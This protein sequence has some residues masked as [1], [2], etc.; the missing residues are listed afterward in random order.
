MSERSLK[1]GNVNYWL[2]NVKI[3]GLLEALLTHFQRLPEKR[4]KII[5]HHDKRSRTYNFTLV[6]YEENVRSRGLSYC[7]SRSCIY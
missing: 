1:I 7:R 6:V 4:R 5:F 2:S 3:S